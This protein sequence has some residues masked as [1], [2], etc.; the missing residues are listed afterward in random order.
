MRYIIILIF[1]VVSNQSW[2]SFLIRDKVNGFSEFSGRAYVI[3]I[4]V[5]KYINSEFN[6]RFCQ[7]DADYF[8]KS[9][10]KDKSIKEILKFS[11]RND[12]TKEQL[13]SAFYEVTKNATKQ[14]LFIFFYSGMVVDN[15]FLLTSEELEFEEIFTLSQ[16]IFADRQIYISDASNGKQFNISFQQF[17]KEKPL[18]KLSTKT[19]R[20]LISLKDYA[21]ELDKGANLKDSTF[22]GGQLTGSISNSIYSFSS[23]FNSLERSDRFWTDYKFD[24]YQT[25]KVD[26]TSDQSV[27][28]NENIFIFSEQD[29]LKEIKQESIQRGNIYINDRIID[30]N[31]EIKKGETLS[32]IIGNQNFQELNKLPNVMNDIMKIDSILTEKYITKNILLKDISYKDFRDTLNYIKQIYTFEEGSQILFVAASHG[33]KDDFGLGYLSFTDTKLDDNMATSFELQNLKRVISSFGATNTLMIM[34][35]CHSGLAFEENNCVSP[36]TPEIPLKSIIFNSPFSQDS[37]A[38]KNFLNQESNLYFGSSRDQEASDGSGP[39][40]P[41]ATVIISFL[42]N[43]K[44]PVIDSF[45]LQKSIENRIMEEGA[46][47][48][49]TFCSY[50][51]K[52]DGRFL[53]IRK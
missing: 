2:A 26:S 36:N 28:F 20:I 14:D 1:F 6:L 38:Y 21:M 52:P 42:E 7:S 41:F 43:N 30:K 17:L 13:K 12:G 15:S 37:P 34:D 8:L 24:L 27:Q 49:P 16:N 23:L 10:E 29:Y 11:I 5:D 50:N 3:S 39:N 4:G 18:E 53:F 44:M 51:C 9:I 46:I 32:I 47:S 19:D 40:S 33:L 31:T 48:F 35:I 25:Y 22:S 45:H